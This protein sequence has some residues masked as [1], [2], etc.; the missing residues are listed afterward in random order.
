M[1]AQGW[2]SGARQAE[3][4]NRKCESVPIINKAHN[5]P[6]QR[7]ALGMHREIKE[8]LKARSIFFRA[9]SQPFLAIYTPSLALQASLKLRP[10]GRRCEIDPVSDA[11]SPAE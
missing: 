11:I 1:L 9:G 10:T 5:I 2:Q 4:C 8:G 3:G 6:A 7:A